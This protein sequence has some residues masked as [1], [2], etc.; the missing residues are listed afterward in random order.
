VVGSALPLGRF[1]WTLVVEASYEAAF[2]P[3]ASL[4][5]RT[6]S[7]HLAIVLVLAGAAFAITTSL[8][9]PLRTLSEAA[10]RLGSGETEIPLPVVDRSDEVGVLARSFAEMVRGVRDAHAT[11]QQLAITDGLTK[12]HNHRFFHDQLSRE[13][14]RCERNGSS[15][16]LILLDIDDFKALNDRFG[17]ASGDAVLE[18]TA[19]LLARSTR[20][21]D[22]VARYGGEEFA[23]L[24]PDTDRN[25]AILLAE[26]VRLA[27]GTHAFHSAEG[28][29][30]PSITVSAGVAVYRGDR[31]GVFAA[32]D[33]ALY[34]AKHEGKDCVVAEPEA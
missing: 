21:Q 9:R 8:V 24:A 33:R 17:H 10:R 31:E 34:A 30:T 12:L 28:H 19:L 29:A 14:R 13:I 25:G 27:I 2:A 1:G 7:I 23:I 18:Q 32:A 5:W 4:L 6:A 26:K 16:A 11:L 15:L 20:D 3:I 22:L